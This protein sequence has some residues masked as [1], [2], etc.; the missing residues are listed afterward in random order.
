MKYHKIHARDLRDAV[1]LYVSWRKS[2]SVYSWVSRSIFAADSPALQLVTLNFIYG[3][4]VLSFYHRR[5]VKGFERGV[6]V[7]LRNFYF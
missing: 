5:R 1:V 3:V 4:E 7:G 6:A 2:T